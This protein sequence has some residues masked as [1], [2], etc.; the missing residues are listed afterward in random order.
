MYSPVSHKSSPVR[1]SERRDAFA[2]MWTTCVVIARS[3]TVDTC[4]HAV[5]FVCWRSNFRIEP[6]GVPFV[7]G[8]KVGGHQNSA[9][10]T[11]CATSLPVS[12][13]LR[14]PV[15]SSVL[16]RRQRCSVSS[17]ACRI[18][19][20][21]PSGFTPWV[22]PIDRGWHPRQITPKPFECELAI[23]GGD[24]KPDRI[25]PAP[26]RG[27]GHRTAAIGAAR[28]RAEPDSGGADQP[29]PS[30]CWLGRRSCSAIRSNRAAARATSRARRS[31]PAAR[32]G[33][34]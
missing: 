34:C 21:L 16:C 32:S 9:F 7:V 25:A 4:S 1:V 13:E 19:R 27:D 18:W 24:A 3:G 31:L 17:L 8:G 29:S 2:G 6:D 26:A 30:R 5:T 33:H 12:R 28:P 15:I 14:L 23:F 11:P 10:S 20:A 22:Y